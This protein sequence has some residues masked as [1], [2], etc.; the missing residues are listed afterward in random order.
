MAKGDTGKPARWWVA[1]RKV[2]QAFAKGEFSKLS[3]KQRFELLDRHCR[4]GL[5][6]RRDRK[7]RVAD[8]GELAHE[9]LAGGLVEVCHR[10]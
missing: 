3:Q 6:H 5:V 8:A 10:P 1:Q 4:E 2:P 7:V 9:R